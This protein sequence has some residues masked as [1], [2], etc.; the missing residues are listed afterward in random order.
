MK[1]E[2]NAWIGNDNENCLLLALSKLDIRICLVGIGA[3]Q[4]ETKQE[5]S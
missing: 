5:G 2:N 1:R 3:E 4:I